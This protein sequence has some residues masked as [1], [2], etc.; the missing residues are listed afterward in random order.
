MKK[1]TGILTNPETGDLYIKRRGNAGGLTIGNT[2]A[3]NQALLLV[4]YPGA[5]KDA[6]TVGAGIADALL[7]TLT[8][9]HKQRIRQVLENDGMTIKNLNMQTGTI[10]ID[11]KYK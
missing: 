7:D 3:Q 2:T 11:A 6:P 1:G 10:E 4:F 8:L 5:V 9:E